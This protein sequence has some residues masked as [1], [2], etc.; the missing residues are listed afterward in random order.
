[1]KMRVLLFS[2][3]SAVVG[4]TTAIMVPQVIADAYIEA[5]RTGVFYVPVND[6]SEP[7]R[8][9]FSDQLASDEAPARKQ[10]R[11]NFERALI[12]VMNHLPN[13]REVRFERDVNL[14]LA[15]TERQNFF[16]FVSVLRNLPHLQK[17]VFN[18]ARL[19]ELEFERFAFMVN[20]LPQL[21]QLRSL[22]LVNNEFNDAEQAKIELLVKILPRLH[23]AS[24]EFEEIEGI[25]D[26]SILHQLMDA[27]GHI[28]N[29]S[30]LR[31]SLYEYIDSYVFDIIAHMRNLIKLDLDSTRI[32]D[33]DEEGR[34]AFMHMLE[35]LHLLQELHLFNCD[36]GV[37][38]LN[39]PY[40]WQGFGKALACL[41]H[42]R[43]LNLE[44]N[45]LSAEFDEDED[46]DD[47]SADFDAARW[48]QVMDA[49]RG[50]RCVKNIKLGNNRLGIVNDAGARSFYLCIS[51]MSEL[52]TISFANNDGEFGDNLPESKTFWQFVARLLTYGHAKRLDLRTTD[53][54]VLD[55]E[56]W[57][58]LKSCGAIPG[59][60]IDVRNC[61]LDDL[62]RY[63]MSQIP[64][65]VMN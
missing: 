56:A 26:I 62:Q 5:E 52:D 18:D 11:L 53:L 22:V 27:I 1:M 51:A 21:P 44:L 60:Q 2:L 12:Y 15:Q 24:F 49:L 39:G 17:I 63:E 64:S 3:L 42:L 34:R 46:L 6:Q 7:V 57:D 30:E 23:L 25:A 29:L 35:R 48:Q 47:D 41:S 65:F 20:M 4:K 55:D 38:P 19:A 8:L 9:N 31:L 16:D 54:T 14:L 13:V 36:M 10:H 43:V 58:V 59:V 37:L 45:H 61:L 28:H 50:I 33:L 32:G 40:G